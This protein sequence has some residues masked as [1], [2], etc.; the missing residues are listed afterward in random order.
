M[1][2]ILA[3]SQDF[4]FS[5]GLAVA[6]ARL[7]HSVV[8]TSRVDQALTWLEQA[9]ASPHLIIADVGLKS[10]GG[11]EFIQHL[12]QAPRFKQIP[13]LVQTKSSR[14]DFYDYCEGAL[15]KPW[16]PSDLGRA[17][18]LILGRHDTSA[19]DQATL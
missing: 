6:L 19:K 15:R 9:S 18:D 14:C 13:V 16:S 11:L 10:F 7:R 4:D 12:K 3:A 1:A 17:V 5:H 2:L 8:A